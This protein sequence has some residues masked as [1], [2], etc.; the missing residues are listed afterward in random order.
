MQMRVLI[1]ILGLMLSATATSPVAA[2]SV[3]ETADDLESAIS[4][5]QDVLD[6]VQGFQG[7]A[8]DD[9]AGAVR[10]VRTAHQTMRSTAIRLLLASLSSKR[11]A[12]FERTMAALRLLEP[13]IFDKAK[14]APTKK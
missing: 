4:E 6:E 9:L 7:S 1:V 5:L 10:A 13:K 14:S 2:Q 8:D 3:N 12:E 11:P